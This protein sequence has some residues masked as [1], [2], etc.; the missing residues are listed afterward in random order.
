MVLVKY[1]RCGNKIPQQDKW[2][3]RCK[4]YYDKQQ[5]KYNKKYDTTKRTNAEFYNSKAWK[6]VRGYVLV[7]TTGIDL[8]DYYIKHA[9][10]KADTVHHIVELKEDYNKGLDI[11][12]L[13]PLSSKNHKRIHLMYLKNKKETQRMLFEVLEKARQDGLF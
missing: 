8:Y 12:N 6:D 10:T 1:C 7:M 3:D 5:A 13:I 4:C 2:C 11:D 9:I